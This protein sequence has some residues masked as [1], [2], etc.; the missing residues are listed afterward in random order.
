[1]FTDEGRG[2]PPASASARRLE[3]GALNGR[4][5]REGP[6]LL[7]VLSLALFG[8]VS[9]F[10]LEGSQTS[11]AQFRK[12]NPGLNGS[13]EFEF[14]TESPNGLLLYTDDGGTY[15]FFEVKLVEGALRLRFNLGG[16]A[17]ILTVGRDLSDG[18]WHK[19]RSRSFFIDERGTTSIHPG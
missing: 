10:S 13:L 16:G 17:Q 3:R 15:D 18:H 12:W 1:M 7:L 2:R 4:G 5:V 9:C 19:V 11:Y 6:L 8:G 14:K